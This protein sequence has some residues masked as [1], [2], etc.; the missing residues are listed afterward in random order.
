[1]S[2]FCPK[3]EKLNRCACDNCKTDGDVKDLIII[4]SVN[5]MYQ[6]SFCNHK[7]HEQESLDIEWD[8]M[9][10]RFAEML[11][12]DICLNWVEMDRAGQVKYQVKYDTTD[13]PFKQAFLIHFKIHPDDVTPDHIVKFRRNLKLQSII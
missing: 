11:S 6:C 1:M 9:L 3:C 12:P 5:N 2:I 8:N 4:D 7:F 10:K 13:Y